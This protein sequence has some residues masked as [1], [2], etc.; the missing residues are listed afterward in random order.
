M[1]LNR[2][3]QFLGNAWFQPVVIS[4]WVLI[5][6]LLAFL[7]SPH[8]EQPV[9]RT[10]KSS[11]L[12]DKVSKMPLINLMAIYLQK[13]KRIIVQGRLWERK[14]SKGRKLETARRLAI[15]RSSRKKGVVPIRNEWTSWDA[16][17]AWQSQ[18]QWSWY[19]IAMIEPL[20]TNLTKRMGELTII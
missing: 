15:A 13:I 17:C 5:E 8:Q 10:R 4:I 2:A 11:V 3:I 14:L 16:L 9:F 6:I 19:S 20:E 12:I 1:W 7:V 18:W